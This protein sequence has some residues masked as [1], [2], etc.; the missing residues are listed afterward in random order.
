MESVS[1]VST[2]GTAQVVDGVVDKVS[3]KSSSSS[4]SEGTSQVSDPPHASVPL[5]FEST[6]VGA[7]QCRA[8]IDICLD[9]SDPMGKYPAPGSPKDPRKVNYRCYQYIQPDMAM[10]RHCTQLAEAVKDGRSDLTIYVSQLKANCSR[11][12]I[13]SKDTS[14]WFDVTYTCT[15]VDP[16]APNPLKGGQ[17]NQHRLLSQAIGAKLVAVLPGDK[18]VRRPQAEPRTTGSLNPSG[19]SPATQKN[20]AK[21]KVKK[22]GGRGGGNSAQPQVSEKSVTGDESGQEP[23]VDEVQSPSESVSPFAVLQSTEGNRNNSNRGRGGAGRGNRGGVSRAGSPANE[24][25]N[26][27][28]ANSKAPIAKA[29]GGGRKGGRGKGGNTNKCANNTNA[30]TDRDQSS[31]FNKRANKSSDKKE[32]EK[33]MDNGEDSY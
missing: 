1:E 30:K 24:T 22:A 2:E 7:V 12:Q 19:P 10:C 9:V 14:T 15:H 16:K 32:E 25:S 18:S 23:K 20:E 13:S 3:T 26:A 21:K 5:S 28:D 31:K 6:G 17:C 4:S 33:R 29:N 27:S 11:I 8:R